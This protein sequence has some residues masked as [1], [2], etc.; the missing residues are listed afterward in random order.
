M[1][2]PGLFYKLIQLNYKIQENGNNYTHLFIDF[3]NIIYNSLQLPNNGSY[4]NIC[5]N[6]IIY[7][8]SILDKINIKD[9]KVHIFVD[10]VCPLLKMNQQKQRRYK[11]LIYDENINVLKQNYGKDIS[12]FDKMCILPGTEFMYLLNT[13]LENY[14]KENNIYFSGYKQ[15]GEGEHKIMDYIKNNNIEGNIL[16]YGLDADL[17]ILSIIKMLQNNKL[18]I[19]LLRHD[20]T[21]FS[22]ISIQKCIEVIL[23]HFKTTNINKVHDFIYLSMFFGNDFIH[24]SP[25]FNL[26]FND[27]D[28]NGINMLFNNYDLDDD[29]TIVNP[30]DINDI[31]YDL[32]LHFLTKISV[33][34]KSYINNFNKIMKNRMRHA[35]QNNFD[36]QLQHYENLRFTSEVFIKEDNYKKD[37]YKI[38]NINTIYNNIYAYKYFELL[39]YVMN[40][41]YYGK[42]NYQYN[43]IM[44]EKPIFITDLIVY[45]QNYKYISNYDLNKLTINTNVLTPLHQLLYVLPLNSHYLLCHSVR[46]YLKYSNVYTKSIKNILSA[47]ADS[48][49]LIY[50]MKTKFHNTILKLNYLDINNIILLVSKIKMFKYESKYYIE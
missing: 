5:E 34:E 29:K 35:C 11:S 27:T 3:N 25:T 6:V 9:I 33:F 19:N 49:N 44:C 42:I 23:H 8:K 14:C 47:N 21:M 4:S 13:Y 32:L 18:Y 39:L 16:I 15:T 46:Q 50:K 41:Y 2:I 36:S 20:T 45:L 10:G 7:T 24:E 38:Y 26:K 40:Y 30:N 37:L 22:Y 12:I 31:N 48:N 1:G 28:M 43:N 17:I